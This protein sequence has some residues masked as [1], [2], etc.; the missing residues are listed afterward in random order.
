MRHFVGTSAAELR[1]RLWLSDGIDRQHQALLSQLAFTGSLSLFIKF[2]Y[3]YM[4]ISLN[5]KFI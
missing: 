1:K 3:P 2:S 5:S 4:S